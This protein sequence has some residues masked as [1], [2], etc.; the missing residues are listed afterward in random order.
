[1]LFLSMSPGFQKDSKGLKPKW[2]DLME[3]CHIQN[4][5]NQMARFVW[6]CRIG[7]SKSVYNNRLTDG[8]VQDGAPM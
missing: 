2:S 7:T 5:S 1:M 8:C 4:L 6:A 3:F